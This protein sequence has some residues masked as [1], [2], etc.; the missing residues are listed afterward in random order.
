[1]GY[2]LITILLVCLYFYSG[3]DKTLKQ[4]ENYLVLNRNSSY[5]SSELKDPKHLAKKLKSLIQE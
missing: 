2:I 3:E 4:T 5:N 1:M